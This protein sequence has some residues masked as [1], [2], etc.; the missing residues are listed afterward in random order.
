MPV[1]VLSSRASYPMRL[2]L[3]CSAASAMTGT[4]TETHPADAPALARFRAAVMTDAPIQQRLAEQLDPAEFTRIAIEWA[5]A[6]G[7]A[8]TADDLHVAGRADPLGALMLSRPPQSGTSW[9]PTQWLPL[10]VAFD[11]PGVDWGHFAGERLAGPFYFDTLWRI[12]A[13]PF[14]RL[15]RYRTPADAFIDAPRDGLAPA[16]F[17]FHMSRSGST[18]VAQMLAAVGDHIVVSEAEPLDSI[19]Q[20]PLFSPGLAAERH[21]EAL[22]AMIAALGRDRSGHSRRYFIKL[23]SWH[24]RALPLFRRAFFDT[25]WIFLYRDPVEVLVSQMRQ[26]GAQTAPGVLPPQIF[27]FAPGEEELPDVDYVARVLSRICEAVIDCWG[28]GGGMLVDYRELPDGV[29]DR[30]LRHFGAE[31]DADE[32]VLMQA[33]SQRNAKAP[34]A[35]FA[36]DSEQKRRDADDATREAAERHLAGVYARLQAIRTAP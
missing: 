27:G 19:V 22:R 18:L 30:I 36:S 26:R 3:Q 23:D 2:R 11:G 9:P 21:V 35:T 33:V 8:I 6:R 10:R 34:G 17:V 25:P 1:T 32:R 5:A 16:G 28:L 12:Q 31:P 7:M 24:T 13:R 29:F 15:F 20:L 14:N 4:M